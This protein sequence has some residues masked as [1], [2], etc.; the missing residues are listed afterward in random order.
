MSTSHDEDMNTEP[1]FVTIKDD[2]VIEKNFAGKV[3]DGN[4]QLTQSKTLY[5]N[6]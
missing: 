3:G 6:G 2:C 5:C 1:L 4:R